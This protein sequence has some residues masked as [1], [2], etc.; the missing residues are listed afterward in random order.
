MLSSFSTGSVISTALS[1]M[2][3]IDLL[4]YG[5]LGS[6]FSYA[7]AFASNWFFMRLHPKSDVFE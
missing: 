2:V 1:F 5:L 6:V 4:V 3:T 7:L